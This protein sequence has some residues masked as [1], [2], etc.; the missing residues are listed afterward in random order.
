MMFRKILSFAAIVSTCTALLI[1]Q[2]PAGLPSN[3]RSVVV[4]I[5]GAKLTQGELEAKHSTALFQA[6]TAYYQAERKA[7]SEFVDE[8]LLER[9]AEREHVTVEQLLEQHVRSTVKDPS[10]EALHV[11]YE[12]AQTNQPYESLRGQILEQIRQG[13][14]AK[15]KLA[16]LKTL[17]GE[18][19]ISYKI[20]PPRVPINLKDTPI[21]G[22]A[23]APVKI[24]EFAD[25]ECPYC[26][27]IEPTL[28]KLEAEYGEKIA[29][30]Y[31]DA[32]LPMHSHAKKA[33]EAAH[34]A[35]AQGKFW[36]YH[37]LLLA[38]K[39][40]ESLQLKEYAK[41]LKLDSEKFDKCLESGE[42]A[43]LVQ[44]QLDE[45]QN[46]EVDGT[47]TFFINGRL[48]AGVLT[49]D[50][51]RSIIKEELSAQT[52]PGTADAGK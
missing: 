29:V 52:A 20:E 16:Y 40:F 49:Y 21:R 30:A 27:Q 25:Y 19:N 38:S 50:Q 2:T 17:R 46:F 26:R 8:Y 13:R 34:C 43:N 10:E 12:G 15:A 22:Q 45:A 1:A 41:T 11:F 37:D 7:L 5:D 23:Q 9:Q 44:A 42:E 51:F 3:G 18:T 31:K 6:R 32:P 4:E 28:K 39:Q 48:F 33:A 14:L 36:E 47:P 35:D 24:V